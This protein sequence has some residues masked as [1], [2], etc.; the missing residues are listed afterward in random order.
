MLVTQRPLTHIRE[1][2]SPLRAG[3][4]EPVAARWMELGCRNHFGKLLHVRGFDVDNIEAL[5]LDMHVP[6][7]YAEIVAA[8]K[9]FAIAIHRDAVDVVCMGI[10]I[11]PSRNG[12]HDGVMVG[13]TGELEVAGILELR[14]RYGPRRA[15]TAGKVCRRQVM[16]Q[17]V[18]RH[19][20]Q[21]LLK[22]LP[23]LDCLIIGRKQK[24]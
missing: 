12:G 5:V 14:M 7:V 18:L 20:L 11:G 16:R 13:E 23:E 10:G 1:L 2:D 19:H 24:V 15:S 17:I 4:H 21:R 8:D 9:R 3:I 6:E 22:N